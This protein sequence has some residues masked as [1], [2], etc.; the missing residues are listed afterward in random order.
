MRQEPNNSIDLLLR[1]L[2]RQEESFTSDLDAQHLDADELN[3]YVA[4]ALPAKT[5]ARYMQHIVDC[6]A[7][8]KMVAQLSAAE[9]VMAVQQPA[10]VAGPS[11]LKSF[12]ASLFS[13]MV[14]RYAV[15]ALGVIVLTVVGLVMFRETQQQRAASV[16]QV[17]SVDQRSNANDKPAA[18]V[19][20]TAGSSEYR[21]REGLVDQT[22]K[23]GVAAP[24]PAPETT[25]GPAIAKT[26]PVEDAERRPEPEKKA[27]SEAD[28]NTTTQDAVQRVNTEEA[29]VGQDA[30]KETA[31]KEKQQTDEVAG[32]P[33][34]VAAPGNAAPR[35]GRAK[36]GEAAGTGNVA[37][38]QAAGNAPQSQAEASRERKDDSANFLFSAETRSVA[39]RQF[40]KRGEI[41]IDA[42]YKAPQAVTVVTRGTEQYR[43]LVADEPEIHTIAENLKSE[44]VV[45]WKGRAYRVR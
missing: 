23:T 5:R 14:L 16:A 8:R 44:F 15:P 22:S 35:Q 31:K 41:W 25:T 33:P 2:G 13:P 42:A 18:Q 19:S 21:S 6:S 29:K 24:A 40:V 28:K 32:A 39:G 27:A 37:S 7:C 4:N 34:P 12:L 10:T 9:G 11:G 26:A 38:T 36:L 1:Q 43:A 30:P 3:S 17:T 45:V 20:P